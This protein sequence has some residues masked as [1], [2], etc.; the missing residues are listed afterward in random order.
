MRPL[1]AASL[2]LPGLL[3][4]DGVADTGDITSTILTSTEEILLEGGFLQ[5][6]S[7]EFTSWGI[8]FTP[9]QLHQCQ[10]Q[11]WVRWKQTSTV[12]MGRAAFT[13]TTSTLRSHSQLQAQPNQQRIRPTDGSHLLSA[14][15]KHPSTP[16]NYSNIPQRENS[17]PLW[18]VMKSVF[19][20][21]Q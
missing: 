2:L 8:N 13:T 7:A 10:E 17:S 6:L 20:S 19:H 1:P 3:D 5:L 11:T 4:K 15:H 16:K 14:V 9:G 18:D 12:S 21:C